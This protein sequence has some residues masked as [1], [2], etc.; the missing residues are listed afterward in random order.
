[1]FVELSLMF[2]NIGPND[3]GMHVIKYMEAECEDDWSLLFEVI[4]HT[5]SLPTFFL[6]TSGDM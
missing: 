4:L 1:M 6:F 5:E 2:L 3:C